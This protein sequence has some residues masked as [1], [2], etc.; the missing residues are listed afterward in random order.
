MEMTIEIIKQNAPKAFAFE[1][2]IAPLAIG[3]K[4]LEGWFLSLSTS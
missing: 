2:L 4:R 3:R 1:M